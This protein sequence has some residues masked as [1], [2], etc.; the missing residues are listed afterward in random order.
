MGRELEQTFL[1]RKYTDRQQ[2]Q[3]KIINITNHQGNANQNQN[4]ISPHTCQNGYFQRQQIT[5]VGED[6]EKREP[7]CTVDGN[8]NCLQPLLQTIWRLLN[9]LKIE[10][11]YDLATLLLHIYQKTMKTLVQKDILPPY[12]LQHYLQFPS[13]GSNVSVH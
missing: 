7:L 10:L 3:E 6:V 9:K 11:S 12:S 13:Y 1:L 5:S 4:E 2:V 8:V